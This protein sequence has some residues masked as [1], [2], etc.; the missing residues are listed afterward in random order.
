MLDLVAPDRI[1]HFMIYQNAKKGFNKPSIQ[2]D[3]KGLSLQIMCLNGW[4]GFVVQ[5]S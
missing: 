2:Q 3:L 1:G 5:I 4:G